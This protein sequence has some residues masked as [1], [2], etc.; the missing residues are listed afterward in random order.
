MRHNKKKRN[1]DKSV[2]KCATRNTING[3]CK[4]A[5]NKSRKKQRILCCP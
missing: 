4:K 1:K 2:S 5:K 3:M